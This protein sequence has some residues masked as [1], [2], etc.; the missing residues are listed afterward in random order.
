MI[1]SIFP[2]DKATLIIMALHQLAQSLRATKTIIFMHY[3]TW[4]NGALDFYSKT[5]RVNKFQFTCWVCL[6]AL[7]PMF[8]IEYSFEVI[9]FCINKS[10]VEYFTVTVDLHKISTSNKQHVLSS[11]WLLLVHVCCPIW[12]KVCGIC[13]HC[14]IICFANT[15]FREDQLHLFYFHIV[16]LDSKEVDSILSLFYPLICWHFILED[17]PRIL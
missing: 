8:G 3:S 1:I 17:Q 15:S 16:T 13:F 11:T 4:L 10:K 7:K 9:M 12:K 5:K 6:L 14:F 2:E